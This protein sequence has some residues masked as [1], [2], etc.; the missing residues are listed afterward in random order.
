MS[1]RKIRV[2]LGERE[3]GRAIDELEEY[4]RSL[5]EKTETCRRRIADEIAGRASEYF[6]EAAGEDTVLGE[7]TGIDVRVEVEERGGMTVIVARGDDVV[8]VEFGAGVYHN[9]AAGSSPHPSGSALGMTIGSYGKGYGK[10]T[11][12]GYYD[13]A[14]DLVITR[15]TPASMPMYRAARDVAAAAAAISRE[16]FG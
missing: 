16:V 14:G 6:E 10:H 8:W 4:R 9:G 11:A 3:I 2:R 15:G 7:K 1:R 12:W 13:G 5:R